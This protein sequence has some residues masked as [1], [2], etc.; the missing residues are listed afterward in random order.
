MRRGAAGPPTFELK[1]AARAREVCFRVVGDPQ[2]RTEGPVRV[3][4]ERLREGLPS[5]V[6]PHVRYKNVRV[7]TEIV[8]WLV[9]PDSPKARL[10]PQSRPTSGRA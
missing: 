3:E 4:R 10:P 7:A 6:Q 2:T 8:A 5:P 1:V 9:S